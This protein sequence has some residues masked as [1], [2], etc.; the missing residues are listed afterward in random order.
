MALKNAKI[1]TVTSVKGGTGKSTL[2]LTLASEFASRKKK[3]L[4][5]DFD[6]YTG[7]MAM[8]LKVDNSANIF[9][10][11]A[12]LMA[13]TFGDAKDYIKEY[14]E[15]ID[16]LPA[17]RDPR[18][19]SKI[20]VKYID[21]LIKKLIHL[22]DIILIDTNHAVDAVKLVSMDMSD[23]IVYVMINDIVNMRNMKT[24]VSIYK[25]MGKDNFSVVLNNALSHFS[26]NKHDVRN[27]IGA[28]VDYVLSKKS[29]S[30][31]IQ[32]DILEGLLPNASKNEE[33]IKKMA[34]D[35]LS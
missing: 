10:F 26:Y 7:A 8:L 11:A 5:A 29:Y 13:N 20:D 22:Y 28:D 12:D 15:F 21:L 1:I 6:L 19:I 16:V 35:L 23:Q 18:S 34:D 17:P 32:K 14:N 25:D 2:L 27:V 31:S 4:I 24:M 3:V 9:N 30:R 33:V